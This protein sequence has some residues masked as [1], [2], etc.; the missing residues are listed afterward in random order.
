MLQKNKTATIIKAARNRKDEI[1]L[2]IRKAHVHNGNELIT[3]VYIYENKKQEFSLIAIP[4]I[5]WSTTVQYEEE[6]GMLKSR[7][8][9]SLSQ[10]VLVETAEELANK[11]IHWVGEM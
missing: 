11:M 4:E 6:R 10:R 9:D 5:E 3:N 7:L 8:I 2:K 1:A